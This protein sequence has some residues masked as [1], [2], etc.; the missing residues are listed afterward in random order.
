VILNIVG[1]F[2]V[3]AL[4]TVAG[5]IIMSFLGMDIPTA[6]GI[7]AATMNNIGPGLGEVGPTDNYAFVPAIGKWILSFFMLLGRLEIFTV[8]ILLIP[9][10]WKK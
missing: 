5:T 7:V 9:S 1:F 3:F 2:V 6:F 10:F 8:M 4:L